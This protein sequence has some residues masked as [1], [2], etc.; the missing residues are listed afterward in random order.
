M[1]KSNS[2]RALKSPIRWSP[3]EKSQPRIEPLWACTRILYRLG[4]GQW[5]GH[6][7][8]ETEESRGC[9][10]D[11]RMLCGR[12]VRNVQGGRDELKA[13]MKGMLDEARKNER[14]PGVQTVLDRS[15]K[16]LEA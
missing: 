10:N 7:N 12:R 4:S 11:R 5:L 13:K 9:R 1:G 2:L 14:S 15:L 16:A 6:R 3:K 8:H